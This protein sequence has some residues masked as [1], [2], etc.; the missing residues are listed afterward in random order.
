MSL[1]KLAAKVTIISQSSQANFTNSFKKHIKLQFLIIIM[2]YLTS[3]RVSDT[4]GRT[5]S[6]ST[7]ISSG[8]PSY[9]R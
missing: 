8:S 5:A 9:R 7:A 4:P 6:V 2:I 3:C 1:Q